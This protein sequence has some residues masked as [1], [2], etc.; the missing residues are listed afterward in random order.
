MVCS[1][2]FSLFLSRIL[3]AVFSS[4]R[5]DIFLHGSSDV[6][7]QIT[8][9]EKKNMIH[10]TSLLRHESRCLPLKIF[11]LLNKREEQSNNVINSS[12]LFSYFWL[13]IRC[14]C[15]F[16]RNNKSLKLLRYKILIYLIAGML[17][18][19][20]NMSRDFQIYLQL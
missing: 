14:T 6:E 16:G 1:S 18:S 17:D 7:I 5:Q 13:N 20:L 2:K 3:V 10:K 12:N 11:Q 15:V 19:F 8:T 4:L 9:F